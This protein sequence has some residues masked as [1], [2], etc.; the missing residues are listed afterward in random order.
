MISIYFGLKGDVTSLELYLVSSQGSNPG[1]SMSGTPPS[2][3]LSSV[4][5]HESTYMPG[6]SYAH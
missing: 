4:F 6:I 2:I 3:G 5:L 1:L